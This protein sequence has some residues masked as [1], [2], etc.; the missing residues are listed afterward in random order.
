MVLTSHLVHRSREL[1]LISRF[2]QQLTYSEQFIGDIHQPLHD[3]NL[4][5]GGNG[6]PVTFDGVAT[7]LHHI[8]DTNMLEKLIG[9][10][11][12]A[13]AEQWANTLTTAIKTGAYQPLADGWLD[14]INL[15][16]PVTTAL[17]WAEEANAFVCT[18]VMPKGITGV[19]N[20]ELGGAYY[21]SSVPVFQLQIARAGY[22]YVPTCC[23]FV[24]VTLRSCQ[25]CSLVGSHCA[26]CQGF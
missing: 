13:Y 23:E 18:T 16:D 17:A 6:I 24:R 3:E 9:G 8:W 20:Q 14:A 11:S 1:Y 12:L 25:T 22:R 7:N 21:Q 5:R 2:S 4:D 10:Y 26:D 19:E 15:S